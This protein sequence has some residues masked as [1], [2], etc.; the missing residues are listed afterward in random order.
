MNDPVHVLDATSPIGAALC[1]ALVA[2][3]VPVVALVGHLA[4]WRALGLAGEARAV[5]PAD[6]FS[7]RQAL[8]DALRIVSA[9]PAARSPALLAAGPEDALYVLLGDAAARVGMPD[10]R[11][12]AVIEAERVFIG[13]GRAGVMLHPGLIYG[14]GSDDPARLALARLRRPVLALPG[15]GRA[16]I[17]PIH[18]DDVTAAVLAALDIPWGP[19]ETLDIAGPIAL[20]RRDWLAAIASS[21]GL[22]LPR[23]VA[24]PPALSLAPDEVRRETLDQVVDITAMTARLGI[25]PIPPDAGLARLFSP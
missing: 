4:A 20:S 18:I 17:Q 7:L 6:H 15:G 13:S 10:E 1:R 5:D 24:W 19:G 8:G 16:L 2:R 22:R 21:A 25:R 12:L 3:E 9:A 11:R 14:A 23:L